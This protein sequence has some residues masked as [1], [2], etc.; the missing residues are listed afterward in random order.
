MIL[1][2]AVIV[3]ATLVAM[4]S[5][6]VPAVLALACAISVA[7]LAGLAEPS[8]LFAG[9]SNGGVITVAAMLV[10]AKGVVHTGVVSR[11][12]WRMMA[13]VRTATQ[14]T[15]RL[16]APV[17]TASA[18]INTT[19]IVAMLIPATKELQQ[20]RGIPVR[21][22]LL[23]VAHGTTLAGST[24]LVGTSSNLLIAGIAGGYGV[25]L[26]MFSF[27][28][29]A[30]PVCLVG[31]VLLAL[32]GPRMFKAAELGGEDEMDW[33]VEIPVSRRAI[34]LNRVPASL[35][36]D[37]TQHYRLL[38]I[39]RKG[40]KVDPD[41]RLAAG[42]T[43]V[44][45]ATEKGVAALWASPRFGLAETRLYAASVATG[46]HGTMA[47]LEADTEVRVVAART[48]KRLRDTYAESGG[49]VYVTCDDTDALQEHSAVAL[50]EKATDKAP[51]PARTR[52]AVAILLGVI[53]A[54]SFSLAPVEL[55]A[56]TGA[57][58]MVVTRVL[59]PR[60]AARALDWN[61]LF[62][63]AGSVGLG[64]IVVES[65]L[66]DQLA[67]AIA[68]LSAGSVVAMVVVMAV[69]TTLLTNITTNAAAA[70]ILTPVSIAVADA[71]SVDPVML[72]A[73]LGTCISFTFV[74][75]FSHQSN[76]MVMG[77]GGY[78]NAS[79]VRLGI[80]LVAVSLV[81]VIATTFLL[82]A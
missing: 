35:G 23:P 47:D 22:V 1:L 57:V 72:L 71:L 48:D 12:T 52:W 60:S 73:L 55:V 61:V 5:G 7:G 10:I 44:F 56:F 9:L 77:P 81:A 45:E 43:L 82:V 25:T 51:Q 13:G 80:P 66:A 58:L 29:V 20:T 79:F 30:V 19:P 26:S 27:A 16:I 36:L 3:V 6:R 67:E 41:E 37:S 28:P 74:N 2:A 68:S 62:I 65:G 78:S 75:P 17:G 50:W 33:R 40:K 70:S 31:W 21:Q 15:A 8:A 14:T 24:T 64:T 39:R 38:Y 4:A 42:D 53:V 46:E 54:L 69:A 76:L 63:L 49:T 11:L 59:T 32:I 34:G 18:L